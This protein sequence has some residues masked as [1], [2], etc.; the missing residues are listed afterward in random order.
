MTAA[1]LISDKLARSGRH[2]RR[3][4]GVLQAMQHERPW[5]L[6]A[7]AELALAMAL[8]S[9]QRKQ[10]AAEAQPMSKSIDSAIDTLLCLLQPECLASSFS[11]LDYAAVESATVSVIELL[12]V[13]S[14]LDDRQ[15]LSI[16]RLM[17]E[18]LRVL[19][20]TSTH[21]AAR[22]QRVSNENLYEPHINSALA[23]SA[24]ASAQERGLVMP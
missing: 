15:S 22:T 20:G 18:L 10:C 14:A 21:R 17:S 23:V 24:Q 9:A 2:A 13:E 5:R 4:P 3:Q 19:L 6:D 1:L 12:R 16:S 8:V 7:E 11:H